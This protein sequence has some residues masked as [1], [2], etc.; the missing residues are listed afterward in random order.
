MAKTNLIRN[1]SVICSILHDMRSTPSEATLW[2]A[3][4]AAR[5]R[6]LQGELADEAPDARKQ[7]M[8]DEVASALTS[9]PLEL[10]QT[11]LETV[12]GEFP[13]PEIEVKESAA[14]GETP[15]PRLPDDPVILV[16]H[17]LSIVPGMAPEQLKELANRL[18]QS[19]LLP[20]PAADSSLKPPE[21]LRKRLEKLAPGKPL[22]PTR[23]LRMLDLLLELSSSLDQ[24]VWQVWKTVAPKSVF[25]PEAGRFGDFR[26]C[27]APYLTGDPEVSTEQVRQTV[28]KTRKLIAGLL[29][30][31]GTV[32]EAYSRRVLDRLSPEAIKKS[33]EAEPGVFENIEKKC[34]RKYSA[35]FNEFT[36]PA[37]EKEVLN[38]IRKYTEKL[39]LGADAAG[40][41]ED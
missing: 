36:G 29:A 22:D 3:D 30:A 39:V 31:M 37:V 12:A 28:E 16:E 18:L 5:L 20:A 35:L 24:L 25:H 17:L 41:L 34:W 4:L 1:P 19:G 26:K 32:G 11:Y 6:L 40:A 2:T 38:A 7:A 33:A 14:P 21:E 8:M 23:A 15:A 10:R 27:L 13:L 9:V